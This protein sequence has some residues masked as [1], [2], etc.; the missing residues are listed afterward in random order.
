MIKSNL[1]DQVGPTSDT[2]MHRWLKSMGLCDSKMIEN[3]VS[4]NGYNHK[5]QVKTWAINLNK[6]TPGP[7]LTFS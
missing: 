2:F 3:L 1:N 7:I 6:I 5:N 4:F